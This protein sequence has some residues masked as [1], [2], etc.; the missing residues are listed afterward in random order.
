T[1]SS[2]EHIYKQMQS[3]IIRLMNDI[4]NK[5]N[6][7]VN[8]K[9]NVAI[10]FINRHYTEV[11]SLEEVAQVVDLSAPYLSRAFGESLGMSF[12]QYV[13]QLRMDKAKKLLQDPL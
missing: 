13:T 2:P 10:D 11:I 6:L 12:I 9:V 8:L 4:R 5:N 7:K 1:W 3:G